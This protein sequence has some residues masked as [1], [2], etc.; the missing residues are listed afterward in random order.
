MQ[1]FITKLQSQGRDS[2][3]IKHLRAVHG[4]SEGQQRFSAVLLYCTTFT[5]E[6]LFG[7]H[8]YREKSKCCIQKSVI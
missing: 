5:A 6:N 8:L 1:I 4:C 2:T 7:H 3:H